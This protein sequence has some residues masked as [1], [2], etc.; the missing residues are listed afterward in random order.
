MNKNFSG[1]IDFG[2]S[3]ILIV[4]VNLLTLG[5]L[6]VGGLSP[7]LFPT[8]VDH[9]VQVNAMQQQSAKSSLQ[10]YTFSGATV[11][12][13]A[14]T[15]ASSDPLAQAVKPVPCG[16]NFNG[17][18]A[19]QS[20][21]AYRFGATPASNNIPAI[22]VFYDGSHALTLG[23]GAVAIMHPVPAAHVINPEIGDTTKTDN[24]GWPF[25]P[26]AIISD[27]SPT[28]AAGAVLD[29]TIA[30]P[31]TDVYGAWK[32]SG[33]P[34]PVTPNGTNT[35]QGSDVWPATNGPEGTGHK[36]LTWTAQ[37]IWKVP[38]LLDRG[39][40]LRSGHTYL[41]H[42]ILHDG[43]GTGE[44]AQVCFTFTNP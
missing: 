28:A 1:K 16:S 43:I 44:P 33:Q 25:Y 20:I 8:P 26:T 22:Q 41:A 39:A 23:S 17:N 11:T 27:I 29:T 10:L 40:P 13:T 42:I 14:S 21:W 35:G 6:F 4:L 31:P 36:D 3:F 37:L 15:A 24:N 19:S 9:V 32:A 34:D 38:S 18:D 5:F 7:K 12:P 30:Q 2:S